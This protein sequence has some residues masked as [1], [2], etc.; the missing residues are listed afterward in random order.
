MNRSNFRIN[1]FNLKKIAQLFR[2]LQI[3]NLSA[4][5]S[6]HMN[7]F[8][9]IFISRIYIE[10][11]RNWLLGGLFHTLKTQKQISAYQKSFCVCNH[12]EYCVFCSSGFNSL[13][14]SVEEIFKSH[15]INHTAQRTVNTHTHTGIF[16]FVLQRLSTFI[17]F[18]HSVKSKTIDWV[19]SQSQSLIQNWI[20]FICVQFEH[21]NVNYFQRCIVC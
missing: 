20:L 12:C 3:K 11:R 18:L 5:K 6:I 16:R 13:S 9:F 21:W 14:K 4:V 10:K 1:I 17:N 8:S 15:L 7:V 19:K 2:L